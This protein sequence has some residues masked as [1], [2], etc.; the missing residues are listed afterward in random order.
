MFAP[1]C[2][3]RVE[4]TDIT[5]GDVRIKETD[6]AV[7][8]SVSDK[9]KSSTSQKLDSPKS[10]AADKMT[11]KDSKKS[12]SGGQHSSQKRRNFFRSQSVTAPKPAATILAEPS[13]SYK[14]MSSKQGS[15]STMSVADLEDWKLSVLNPTTSSHSATAIQQDEP[16]LT[17]ASS[18]I[19]NSSVTVGFDVKEEKKE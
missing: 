17:V 18:L 13:F 2:R 15:L 12:S 7:V 11:R 9:A 1:N 3:F 19:D 5:Q 6:S 4:S 10:T 16:I 8:A 14:C